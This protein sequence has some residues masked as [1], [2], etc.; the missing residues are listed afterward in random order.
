[1]KYKINK[2]FESL[3]NFTLEIREIFNTQSA[4]IHKARNELKV[5]HYE[6]NEYVVKSF[7]KPNFINRIVYT[8][9]RE[10][11]ARKSYEYSLKIGE[12]TPTPI[13]FIEFYSNSLLDSSFFIAKKYN[14]DFTIRVP[15]LSSDFIQKEDILKQFA[16]FT[17]K[18]HQN[19]ILHQDYSPGNILIKKQEFEYEFKIVDINRMKFMPLSIGQRLKNFSKLWA[20]DEDLKTIVKEYSKLIKEDELECVKIALKFSHKQKNKINAK[21]RLRGEKV[22][23]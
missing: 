11:K 6:N 10:S 20:S 18:L 17:Y 4:S 13:S 12:F 1:M 15:L 7:K 19:N 14:Y 8:F 21:K 5:I 16:H 22:V 2:T 9:F 3:K 23:D